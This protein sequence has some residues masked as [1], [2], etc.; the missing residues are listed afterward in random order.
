MQ[1]KVSLKKLATI[2]NPFN[3]VVWEDLDTPITSD[4]IKKYIK[5][6]NFLS[7]PFKM[8]ENISSNRIREY[9]LARIAYLVENPDL[10]PIEIDVGIPEKNVLPSWIITD[11]NH[12]LAAALYRQDKNIHANCSGSH[13]AIK[14]ILGIDIEKI[15][16]QDNY[17]DWSIDKSHLENTWNNINFVLDKIVK[18]DI[19]VFK[20]TNPQLWKNEEFLNKCFTSPYDNFFM[21][22][23]ELIEKKENMKLLLT[24][25]AMKA[26][27]KNEELLKQ[28]WFDILN[29]F[30]DETQ[31]FKKM[32]GS[33][34]IKDIVM[35]IRQNILDDE[36]SALCLVSDN[37]PS[38]FKHLSKRLK[39]NKDILYKCYNIDYHGVSKSDFVE[40]IPDD[41]FLDLKENI[42]FLNF[43]RSFPDHFKQR[44]IDVWK[45]DGQKALEVLSKIHIID[46]LYSKL[47]PRLK[48][49]K[50]FNLELI[51]KSE[52]YLKKLSPSMIKDSQIIESLN[53]RHAKY[54]PKEIYPLIK[55]EEIIKKIISYNPH[56]LHKDTWPDYWK[57]K[58]DYIL[59]I[60]AVSYQ[61][62]KEIKN[63]S[64]FCRSEDFILE[65]SKKQKSIYPI[66]QKKYKTSIEHNINYISAGGNEKLISPDLWSEPEF[67]LKV[68]TIKTETIALFSNVVWS[69]KLFICNFFKKIDSKAMHYEQIKE[70]LPNKIIQFLDTFS[71]KENFSEFFDSYF[72]NLSLN[73][74]LSEKQ[75]INHKQKI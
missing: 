36:Q 17:F 5:E 21:Y 68:A 25:E 58:A 52:E 55:N 4:E 32:F 49:D 56:L 73:R 44:A 28:F 60:P 72:L 69:D 27:R 39:M 53:I 23:N 67:C 9:H 61:E 18:D 50:K 74:N 1:I 10:T 62:L 48:E 33:Q 47:S 54:I 35:D 3:S 40:S 64:Q 46:N 19:T 6:K 59:E 57:I 66:I 51:Q 37:N 70:F 26:Y 2:A 15:I 65:L 16:Q 45:D 42:Q 24:P 12:R 22:K 20:L 31:P 13:N 75:H 34:E 29:K 11:G 7:I 30:F 41:Y 63:F 14:V 43:A 8:Q 71:V 38:I